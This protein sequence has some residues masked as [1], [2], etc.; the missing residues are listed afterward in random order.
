MKKLFFLFFLVLSLPLFCNP[1]GSTIVHGDVQISAT[2]KELQI[3]ASDGAILHWDSFSIAS[4]EAIRFLQP[5]SA[6]SVLNRITGNC[7]SELLGQLIANGQIFLLNPNGVLI[8]KD[9]RIDTAGF[10]VSTLNLTNEEFLKKKELLFKGDSKESIENLGV[11]HTTNGNVTLLAHIVKNNGTIESSSRVEIGAGCEIL[12]EVEGSEKIFIRPCFKGSFFENKGEIAAFQ[13]EIKAESNPYTQA[14]RLDGRLFSNEGKIFISSGDSNTKIGGEIKAPKGEIFIHSSEL[15]IE[16]SSLL[17]APNGK[18]TIHGKSLLSEGSLLSSGGTIFLQNDSIF[19]MGIVDVSG[20]KA[21]KIFCSGSL[22]TNVGKIL[23]NSSHDKGG[24]IRLYARDGIIETESS[25]I[26]ANGNLGGEIFTQ[27]AEGKNRLFT[28]GTYEA[29]GETKGG[30]IHL[31]GADL[32]LEASKI[33]A[34]GQT[35]GGEILIGGDFQG[36]N[37]TIENAQFLHVNGF[38]QIR[39][40]ALREGNGGRII[41]FSEGIAEVQ[42]EISSLGGPEK[43]D[44]GF[45][46]ISGKERFAVLANV[47]NTAFHGKAGELLLDP[48]NIVIDDT[49]GI[50]PQYQF[51]NPSVGGRFG[52]AVV[53]LSTGKVAITD[54]NVATSTGAVYLYDGKTAALTATLTGSTASDQ[55]GY[56]ITGLPNGSYVVVSR[57]WTNAGVA[58]CGAITLCPSGGL[59]G[60][61]TTSNS[62]VGSSNGDLVGSNGV[63]IVSGNSFIVKSPNWQNAGLAKAGAVTFFSTTPVTGPVSSLNSLVGQYANDQVGSAVT[64]LSNGNYV[65]T[66]ANWNGN[67]GAVTFSSGVTGNVGIVGLGNSLVGTLVTDSVGNSGAQELTGGN[68]II[69]SVNW[70]SNRGAVTWCPNT[71]LIGTISAG[72]SLVGTTPGDFVSGDGVTL[73]TNGNYVVRT[74]LWNGNLGAATL[75]Q[76]DGSTLGAVSVANSLVGTTPG[77]IVSWG[78]VSALP[79]GNY[80]VISPGWNNGAFTAAGAVTWCP[81]TGLTGAV[82]TLNSLYGTSLNDAVGNLGIKVLSDGNYV[83]TSSNWSS[84]R[85]AVTWGSGTLGLVGAVSAANSL[86]GNIVGDRIGATGSINAVYALNG[87]NY[88]VCSPLCTIGFSL[89]GALTWCAAGG[90]VGPVTAVNSVCGSH[91]SDRVGFSSTTPGFVLPNGSCYIASFFWNGNNGAATYF[92]PTGLAG[93]IVSTSNSLTAVGQMN[94]VVLLPTGDCVICST[95]PLAGGVLGAATYSPSTG[96]V[97]TV[98]SSNSLTGTHSN[99]NV[100]SNI[101]VLSNVEYLVGSPSWFS[102]RGAITYCRTDG[103]NSGAVSAQNSI[104]GLAANSNML[105]AVVDSVNQTFIASFPSESPGVVRVGIYNP[106]QLDYTRAQGQTITTTSGFIATTLNKGTNVTLQATNSITFNSAL[107][108]NTAASLT[109]QSPLINLNNNITSTSGMMELDGNV[110]LGQDVT[111]DTTAGGTAP[112]GNSVTF[113]GAIEGNKSLHVQAGG[114][115]TITFTSSVGAVQPLTNLLAIGNNVVIQGNMQ[116]SGGSIKIVADSLLGLPSSNALSQLIL[117]PGVSIQGNSVGFWSQ[118]RENNQIDPSVRINGSSFVSNLLNVN[119]SQE[120]WD[121]A[122]PNG[123][124]DPNAPFFTF[125]YREKMQA[126]ESVIV[127]AQDQTAA[128]W[129]EFFSILHPFNEYITNYLQI[130]FI[131]KTPSSLRRKKKIEWTEEKTLG[132]FLRQRSYLLPYQNQK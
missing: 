75:C 120:V 131:E 19:Q 43:G 118:R 44:G 42:G 48:Q 27:V 37:P 32:C 70:N 105:A 87:G 117:G 54:P 7:K 79:G 16:K 106:N 10:L 127:R 15:E 109:L 81:S 89:S 96:I 128:A 98:S 13:E 23:A 91:V 71:G 28:S 72:N 94:N 78:G 77:D 121:V 40:D 110:F 34:S 80:V 95:Q 12:L 25:Y 90:V 104:V 21:G 3:T 36:K 115:G 47:K 116:V 30:T 99:D 88:I 93:Q 61:V 65:A 60:V 35:G 46:E 41:L 74:R 69:R 50:Y 57:G 18:I 14:I 1:Q 108:Y 11:I 111:I 29:I 97:G 102:H 59:N 8:G 67:T 6:S 5:S 20:E 103:F 24:R 101:T 84:T 83:V 9:A 126:S 31:F 26:S 53:A 125:F 51:I 107:N 4:D 55:V 39:A 114:S 73:L 63:A 130:D 129:G 22:L 122:Y 45:I 52:S 17:S 2:N 124:I 100:G 49:T 82:T 58:N 68:Y 85:G 119:S 86:V 132:F 76:S 92:P 33:N 56:S 64:V 38:S 66:T 62:L 113:N 123:T 112:S